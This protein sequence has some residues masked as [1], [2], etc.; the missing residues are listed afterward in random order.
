[1]LMWILCSIILF[2]HLRRGLFIGTKF[3][4]MYLN[5][6]S[7]SRMQNSKLFRPLSRTFVS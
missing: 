1:V 7:I 6:T 4:H 3:P 5:A 2:L